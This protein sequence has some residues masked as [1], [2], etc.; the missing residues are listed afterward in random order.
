MTDSQS[1]TFLRILNQIRNQ[2]SQ[3]KTAQILTWCMNSADEGMSISPATKMFAQEINAR[4]L[5]LRVN[6]SLE[7][8]AVRAGVSLA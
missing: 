7:T 8:L 6:V 1:K 3:E 2:I 4:Y 5:S